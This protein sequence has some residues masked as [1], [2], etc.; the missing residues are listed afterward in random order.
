M[1]VVKFDSSPHFGDGPAAPTR[2]ELL[3]DQAGATRSKYIT[4]N[5][6]DD[7]PNFNKVT[8]QIDTVFK[9]TDLEDPSIHEPLDKKIE[10]AKA[11]IDIPTSPL[12]KENIDD[13]RGL[14]QILLTMKAEFDKLVATK[15]GDKEEQQAEVKAITTSITAKMDEALILA[16]RL[17]AVVVVLT[18]HLRES[19]VSHNGMMDYINE[20]K[21]YESNDVKIALY[22]IDGRHDV[23]E[24]LTNLRA[25]F[26]VTVVNSNVWEKETFKRGNNGRLYS[27]YD[28]EFTEL[29][30]D[31]KRARVEASHNAHERVKKLYE[32]PATMEFREKS[33]TRSA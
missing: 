17:S 31:V 33:P 21:D 11:A 13:T 28:N 25:A 4:N 14:Q 22:M 9:R 32:N 15:K 19:K 6:Q 23:T 2:R 1:S 24:E 12:K 10:S 20:L 29:A 3:L 16:D 5:F 30:R 26:D 8:G 7:I 18:R 27:I